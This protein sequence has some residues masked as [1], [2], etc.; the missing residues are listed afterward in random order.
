MTLNCII[1]DDSEACINRLSGYLAES[2]PPIQLIKSYTDPLIALEEMKQTSETDIVFIGVLDGNINGMQLA[3]LLKNKIKYLII[4]AYD[5]SYALD[6]FDVNAYNYLIK[7]VIKEKIRETLKRILEQER[8]KSNDKIY[9]KHLFIKSSIDELTKI[10]IHDILAVQGASN[11]VKIHTLNQKN[12]IIYGKMRDYEQK[13]AALGSFIRVNRSF[14][15]ST[16]A[17]KLIKK[18]KITLSNGLQISIGNIYKDAIKRHLNMV[19]SGP[20]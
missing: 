10:Y 15:I 20:I 14:I 7:P 3:R 12:Y 11:Y 17:I 4:T 5:I 19:N 2:K 9:D 6:A 18:R 16:S 1:I 13:L 8:K